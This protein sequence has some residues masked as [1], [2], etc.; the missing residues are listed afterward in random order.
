MSWWTWP[1]SWLGLMT[2][3]CDYCARAVTGFVSRLYT[4]HMG[5][6]RGWAGRGDRWRQSVCVWQ[7]QSLDVLPQFTTS[8][9]AS[10][11]SKMFFSAAHILPSFLFFYRSQLLRGKWRV[12]VS[13]PSFVRTQL[14]EMRPQSRERC[15]IVQS[16]RNIKRW[17]MSPHLISLI[18]DPDN[19][20]PNRCSSAV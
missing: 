10:P 13:G 7:L 17:I 2:I 11:I 1:A 12:L 6:W 20:W 8:P 18:L 16:S 19:P 9:P 3:K 4:V 15:R 5:R 14:L